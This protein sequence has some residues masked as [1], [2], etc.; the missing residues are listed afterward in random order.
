MANVIYTVAVDHNT[1][2]FKNLCFDLA[3][4]NADIRLFDNINAKVKIVI[5]YKKNSK[6][7]IKNRRKSYPRMA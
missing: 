1:S 5:S 2:Q 3:V 7:I 6:S 4:S